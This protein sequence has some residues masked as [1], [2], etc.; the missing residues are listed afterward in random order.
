MQNASLINQKLLSKIKNLNIPYFE[1]VV[2]KDFEKV[3]EFKIKKEE[4]KDKNLLFLFSCTKPLT[5]TATM[6]LVERGKLNLQDKLVDYIPSFKNSYLLDKDGNKKVVGDRI[7]IEHLLTMTAGFDYNLN[8]PQINALCDG[9]Y[10]AT[11]EEIVD[12]IAET[13]L[14]FMPGEKFNYSLCHDVLARVI[15][16]VSG[17]KFSKFMEQEIF[18]P[19]GMTSCT[20]GDFDESKMMPLYSV[21]RGKIVKKDLVNSY[22]RTKNYESGGAGLVGTIEDYNK[23]AVCLSNGGV[24]QN[25]YRLLKEETI[26]QIKK[27]HIKIDEVGK[28]FTCV[29]GDDYSYGLGVRTRIKDT[30]WGLSKGEFGWDG[31]AG[32]YLMVDTA[33][34]ISIVMGMHLKTWPAIFSG[35]HLDIVKIIYENLI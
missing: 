10:M 2:N 15:E 1:I 6:R 13:P 29:Q 24:S 30:E 31:A 25:G 14:E 35:E 28:S 21:E 33:K 19:L 16:V 8:T 4:D 32:S 20:F 23:F 34:N 3:Y 12:K 22:R 17:T 27:A 11:T 7:T 26:E 18:I 5:V 9:G